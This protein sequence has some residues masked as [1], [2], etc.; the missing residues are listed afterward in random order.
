MLT[1]K[2]KVSYADMVALKEA[3]L[4]PQQLA[5]YIER[6]NNEFESVYSQFLRDVGSLARED[7]Q[8]STEFIDNL[9]R[10]FDLDD[11]HFKKMTKRTVAKI[12]NLE[13]DNAAGVANSLLDICKIE[14][15]LS[16][17]V[18]FKEKERH[19]ENFNNRL[20]NRELREMVT[21][22]VGLIE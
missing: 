11:S 3:I 14:E 9:D 8:A 18:D 13:D 20:T 12:L 4:E 16:K 10:P 1:A 2:I 21:V 6:E 22:K 7:P 19:F 15:Y 5:E 17:V